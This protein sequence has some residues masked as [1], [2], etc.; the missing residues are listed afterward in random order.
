MT[1]CSYLY[2][3]FHLINLTKLNISNV[4]HIVGLDPKFGNRHEHF[5][6]PVLQ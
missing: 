2:I 6:V 4:H 3:L 1:P 5:E